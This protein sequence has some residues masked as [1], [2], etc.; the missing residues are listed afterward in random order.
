MEQPPLAR[1]VSRKS[2]LLSMAGASSSHYE[3]DVI[4]I[5]APAS[6]SL[7]HNQVVPDDIIEIDGDDDLGIMLIDETTNTVGKGKATENGY[8]YSWQQVKYALANDLVGPSSR[9]FELMNDLPQYPLDNLEPDPQD[10]LYLEEDDDDSPDFDYAMSLQAQFDAMD[11]PPGVEASIPWLL[12]SSES[13]KTRAGTSSSPVH[14]QSSSSCCEVELAEVDEVDDEV[15]K[16]YKVFKQFDSIEDY[17]DHFY[18]KGDSSQTKPSK[19]WAKTIQEEWKIME[20]GLPDT[21]FVRVYEERMDLLRA[22]IV[23]A[24]GTPY[25]DGLFFFDVFFPPN[26]PN[27]PPQVHYHSGGLRLNPNLYH[28]GYVCLSLLN[29]WTGDANQKWIP[30]KSTM[31]QV[32]VSIQA[33][34]L[35]DEPYFNEPGYERS[36]GQPSGE[37]LSRKYNEETFILSCRTM[38]YSLNRPPKNFE[39]FV[40]GHFYKRANDILEACKAYM[41]G[42]EVG[43]VVKGGVQKVEEGD[44]SSSKTFKKKVYDISNLLFTKFTEIGAKGCTH[45]APKQT[46]EEEDV[47]DEF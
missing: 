5:K 2:K 41:E 22:V 43:C 39:D 9:D 20:T 30:G 35:N 31:L 44:K 27:V 13:Q 12:D 11:I 46:R 14:S 25:H 15:L 1:F 28:S 6:K 10:P 7:K 4:E 16:K 21:I 23:G 19:T 17:S 18:V 3:P 37:M 32:L 40:I 38:L 47:L 42:A 24:A 26:Y 45:L 36:R 8:D 33:L 34:V 29:T